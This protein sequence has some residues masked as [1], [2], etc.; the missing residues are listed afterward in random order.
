MSEAYTLTI[1]AVFPREKKHIGLRPATSPFR[2]L[3]IVWQV[4][5]CINSK[6][7]IFPNIPNIYKNF[8]DLYPTT[9]STSHALSHYL[10]G[11]RVCERERVLIHHS[12]FAGRA[13]VRLRRGQHPA[14]SEQ[15]YGKG[16]MDIKV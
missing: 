9:L 1:P 10:P 14:Q 12:L 8:L 4:G 13:A 7:I 6:V 11:E 5:S 16:D 15:E 3:V 2:V